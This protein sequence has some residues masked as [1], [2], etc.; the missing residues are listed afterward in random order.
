MVVKRH[1]RKRIDKGKDGG[2]RGTWGD[3][4]QIYKH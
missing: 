3:K 4:K 2:K 1:R